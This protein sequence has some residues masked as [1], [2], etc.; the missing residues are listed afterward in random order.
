MTSNLFKLRTGILL[1][2][3]FLPSL[4]V[5][6]QTPAVRARVIERVDMQKL[7]T[8]RGNVH[9]L[10]RQEF[11][12][13]VAPD[14]LPMQRMLLVL[15]RAPEQE[16]SLRQLLD[17]QQ[18]KSSP[19]FHQWLTPEQFG[20]Q[21]GPADS[22]VQAVTVWLASQGFQVTKVAAGRTVIEF[23]GTAGLVR[24]VLGTEIHRFRVNGE[25]SWANTHDP[26][27]PAALAPVVAGFASLNNFPLQPTSRVFLRSHATGDLTTGSGH[28]DLGPTDFATI[29]NVLPLWSAGIDGTGQTIAIVSGTNINIQ[30]VRDFRSIFALPARDPQIIVNGPD[31]GITSSESEADLDVQWSGAVAKGA[32]IDLVVSQGTAAT[33]GVDL[34]IE[35]VIDNDLAPVMSSS[36][37][38]CE[39]SL[40]AAGNAFT[41]SIREQGAA[42][43]ITMFQSSGDAGSA[44]CDQ[45]L[46][47]IGA[48]QGLAINGF[49]STPFTV[50]V[51]GTDFNDVGNWSQYWNS[52]NS[53]TSMS[54]ARSYI[55]E[56]TWNRSCA[57]AGQLSSCANA[58]SDTAGSDT[59]AGGGGPSNC[60]IWSGANCAG[61]PKPAWQAGPGVPNDGVRDIPDV[62]LFSSGGQNGSDSAYAICKADSLAAGES[63]CKLGTN[64]YFVAISGTSAAA[65]SFAGIMAMLNQKTGERQGNANYVL[66]PLAAQPG[67]SCTSNAAA[68]SNSN[69]IFYDVVVG[70]NSVACVAGSPNCSNQ[71]SSGYGILVSPADNITPAWTTT[72]G[73]DLATGLGSVNAANLVNNWES[74]SPSEF[75]LAANPSSI[76]I[77][78]PG[79]SGTATITLAPVNGFVGLV[80]LSVASGCPPGGTCTVSS[81][82]TVGGTATATA[83]LTVTT[84]GSSSISPL[85]RIRVPPDFRLPLGL[86][87]VL[88][89]ALALAMLLG[90]SAIR[91]RPV[92]LLLA[93]TLLVV[94]VWV[95]CGG[96]SGGGGTPAPTPQP[97]VSLSPASLIFGAEI[98]GTSS[99]AQSVTLTNTGNAALSITSVGLTGANSGD[100]SQTNT[101][102][103]VTAGANCSISVT[104]TPT[105]A[106]SRN[107]SVSIT[108][109]ATGSPQTVNLSGTGTAPT[110]AGTYPIVVNAVSGAA[111]HSLTVNVTVQ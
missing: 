53:S 84:T 9:P 24:Q 90:S 22:D 88:A 104:F 56:T 93:T 55:P 74:V 110:P 43:G 85:G 66:Y 87:W 95:A 48:T 111:S 92:A 47:E 11:D 13:G 69:C 99:A 65:P 35:Y 63:S 107:A 28:Y 91:R 34:S 58:A 1:V 40:G 32:T 29:Y 103:S 7:A 45:K 49:G 19:R 101:C 86:I 60:G 68:V 33:S 94:G 108:D 18:V 100:F 67:A 81:P 79:Q 105:A 15:Q 39:Q 83:T 16:T 97:A 72:P 71:S 42:E 78:A 98:T 77:P 54:S 37:G 46:G 27:I 73:Y 6:A 61:Y 109:N 57:A 10:A 70:N 25:D 76:N 52:T 2:S 106:G 14:D 41:Y 12:Q 30:D 20:Q 96:G 80:S 89:G 5:L 38:A 23:S 8:L 4:S 26:Q 82:V 64:W 3:I 36:Y 102:S 50:T 62:S 51:G 17:D 44:R 75:G 31:P 59:V 21:F